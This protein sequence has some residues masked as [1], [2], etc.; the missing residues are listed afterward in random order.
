MIKGNTYYYRI[1]DEIPDEVN[2]NIMNYID[3]VGDVQHHQTNVKAQ[4]TEWNLVEN[5][6]FLTIAD[7]AVKFSQ[8][9][10]Q[11]VYNRVIFPYINDVWGMKYKSGEYA[12]EHDHWP[13]TFSF[14]YYIN[15]PENSTLSFPELNKELKNEHKMLVIF[16]GW[17]LHKVE[18]KQFSGYRYVV[19]GNLETIDAKRKETIIKEYL[20]RQE[21]GI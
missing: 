1:C 10:G 11:T 5:E 15:P 6:N 3:L 2:E 13:A 14:A 9:I 20:A 17:I 8:S 19:S 12:I 7:K 16:P 4:M 18:A 21:H